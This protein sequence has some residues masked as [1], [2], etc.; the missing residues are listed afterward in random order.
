MRVRVVFAD[1]DGKH[2]YT[3]LNTT[4]RSS[5]FCIATAYMNTYLYTYVPTAV[6][7]LKY[8]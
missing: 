5:V 4:I 8:Q 7:Y 1:S 6:A 2:G 3:Q